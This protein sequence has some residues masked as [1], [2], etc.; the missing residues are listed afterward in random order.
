MTIHAILCACSVFPCNA[1][2]HHPCPA[3]FLTD[4]PMALQECIRNNDTK[5][6]TQRLHQDL[7]VERN[8]KAA[9][10]FTFHYTAFQRFVASYLG[11]AEETKAQ[12]AGVQSSATELGTGSESERQTSTNMFGA[13]C[14]SSSVTLPVLPLQVSRWQ[15]GLEVSVLAV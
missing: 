3:A 8:V 12:L 1:V 10:N 4:C 14:S 5:I 2:C 11:T 13:K 9:L 6:L 15:A 7:Y